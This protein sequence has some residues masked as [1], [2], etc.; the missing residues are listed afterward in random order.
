VKE[1]TDP[2]KKISR[3]KM[4]PQG[5]PSRGRREEKEGFFG[6]LTFMLLLGEKRLKN[7]PRDPQV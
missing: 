4:N 3:K 2:L 6:Q 7:D 1:I 5:L